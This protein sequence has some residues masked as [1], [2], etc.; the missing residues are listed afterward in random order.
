MS[1]KCPENVLGDSWPAPKCLG[2]V[3]VRWPVGQKSF[4]GLRTR[5]RGGLGGL[6][7]RMVWR[8]AW[9]C[10][11]SLGSAGRLGVRQ[12]APWRVGV[13]GGAAGPLGDARGSQRLLGGVWA[14]SGCY[15]LPH[16]P[17]GLGWVRAD[18]AQL[19]SGSSQLGSPVFSKNTELPKA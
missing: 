9:A 14:G 19:G 2:H 1:G 8:R 6:D 11:A 12:R 10:S 3:P 17:G 18:L 7:G 4:E 15:W 16:G 5:G 13:D